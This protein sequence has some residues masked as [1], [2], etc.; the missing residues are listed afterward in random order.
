MRSTYADQ[1][2]SLP[3]SSSSGSGN[4]PAQTQPDSGWPECFDRV[5]IAATGPRALGRLCQRIQDETGELARLGR[6]KSYSQDL[7][8]GRARIQRSIARGQH[9]SDV[10]AHFQEKDRGV[11]ASDPGFVAST[12]VSI[13]G[14][15]EDLGRR[16]G[17]CTNSS[18][19]S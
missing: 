10:A 12:A 6:L 14:A 3:A 16:E 4:P 8:E 1:D 7:A 19:C 2:A 13:D 15:A 17:S 18:R 9:S 5:V 11:R